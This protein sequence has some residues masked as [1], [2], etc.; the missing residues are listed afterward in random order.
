[1]VGREKIS[2]SYKRAPST[3]EP[4]KLF[5]ISV[6][7]ANDE[8]KYFEALKDEFK[9]NVKFDYVVTSPKNDVE[10]AGSKSAPNHVI[11]RLTKKISEKS[12]FNIKNGDEAWLVIDYDRWGK[13]LHDVINEA[14]TN[15]YNLAISNISFNTW[16][17]M[18]NDK[19]DCEIKAQCCSSECK[20]CSTDITKNGYKEL[21]RRASVAIQNAKTCE[22]ATTQ[23]SKT[24]IPPCPGSRMYKL[25]E[26][27]RIS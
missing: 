4:N 26:S 9:L 1:M 16:L 18:H 22:T 20:K 10:N 5:I 8:P 11:R 15:K 13:V 23:R 2:N 3:K 7:G 17:Y 25:L 27:L 14:E 19:W 6:E 24:Q 12:T 21:A